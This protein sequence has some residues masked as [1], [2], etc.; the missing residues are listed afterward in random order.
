MVEKYWKF[1]GL[2]PCD[3]FKYRKCEILWLKSNTFFSSLKHK[4]WNIL[5]YSD[6]NN[7]WNIYLGWKNHNNFHRRKKILNCEGMWLNAQ[8][9]QNIGV[10]FSSSHRSSHW[11][12]FDNCHCNFFIV[13]TT[14]QR[15][16]F[17]Y[18][19]YSFLWFSVAK[20][21]QSFFSDIK[22]LATLCHI[23]V[24]NLCHEYFIK[25]T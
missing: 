4:K 7:E 3:G 19:F 18:S 22:P 10:I 1:W 25:G 17:I 12:N 14:Y 5:R 13:T 6:L 9:I 16:C 20:T 11:S 24:F 23:S 21:I 15:G 8:F 2:V